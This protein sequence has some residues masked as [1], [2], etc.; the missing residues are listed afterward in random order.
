MER[1]HLVIR[2]AQGYTRQENPHSSM[3]TKDNFSIDTIFL[4]TT[5]HQ[6][7]TV[8]KS[9]SRVYIP[10]QHDWAPNFE[11]QNVWG[12]PLGVSVFRNSDG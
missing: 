7:C 1:E 3:L 8:A 11:L 5:Y 6:P 9:V 2:R 12:S 4:E 10:K